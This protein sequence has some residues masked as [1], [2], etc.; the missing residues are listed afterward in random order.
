[1]S[2]LRLTLLGGQLE[3]SKIVRLVTAPSGRN[4][5]AHAQLHDAD[6]VVQAGQ[7]DKVVGHGDLLRLQPFCSIHVVMQVC[8]CPHA[9]IQWCPLH[10]T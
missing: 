5:G 10:W 1:M 4:D 2:C 9:R 6:S 7:A 3:E 8:D